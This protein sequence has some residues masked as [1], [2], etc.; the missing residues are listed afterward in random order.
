MW[1]VT[2]RGRACSGK[3]QGHRFE[4]SGWAVKLIPETPSEL[5]RLQSLKVRGQVPKP[6]TPAP[7]KGDI[8]TGADSKAEC[9]LCFLGLCA[10]VNV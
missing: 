6:E 1:A 8:R 4:R 9:V 7:R 3:A 5:Q 2:A 10:P